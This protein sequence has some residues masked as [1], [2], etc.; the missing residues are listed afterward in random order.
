MA[1]VVEETAQRP[2]SICIFGHSYV[3]RLREFIERDP[4][5]YGNLGLD[6]T[7]VSVHCVG[8]GGATARP[9]PKCLRNQLHLILNLQPSVVFIHV[10]ENDL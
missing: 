2:A 9:G 6:A 5:K 7:R 3:R 10:G 1:S 8:V 4:A